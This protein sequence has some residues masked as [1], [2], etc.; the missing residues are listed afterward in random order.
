MS[1]R[2]WLAAA[3]T[4]GIAF[5]AVGSGPAAAQNWPSRPVT[6]VVPF[7]AGSGI[8]VLGRV[9]AA[10]LAEILG[11]QVVVENVGGAGGMTGASRVAKAMPDGYQFLLGNVGTHAQN[12]SLYLKPLY[13]AAMDF[14]PVVLIADT[15]QVLIVRADL[16]VS[17]LQ[18]FVTYAK[19]NQAKMQYGSPGS[20][21]AA[22][23]GCV[24]LNAALGVT[25]THVP[26][27]GGATVMQ[28][29][30]AGRIDYSCPLAA[31]AIPQIQ[32][33]KVKALA[34]LTR[35]RSAILPNLASV[36]EQGLID[37]EVSTWNAFF[38]PKGTPPAIVHR[39]RDSTVAAIDLPAVQERLSRL[40]PNRWRPS[41]ARRAIC[42]NSSKAKSRNGRLR[43]RPR[44]RP[45]I[46]ADNSYCTSVPIPK[47][48][49]MCS[50]L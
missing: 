43:S 35:S 4:V 39:L 36:H 45:R 38:L 14:A 6:M 10:P 18:E 12:Q 23:L 25:V 7:G 3:T 15:P 5:A 22:H 24:L 29:L 2:D 32:S 20:G 26:Y 16:P 11:Q 13:N 30:I 28:D 8:D 33:E 27:R 50:T 46:R 42:K 49:R 37:F 17:N 48:A 47:F 21:S 9:L 41:V 44:E 31:L 1:R 40:E 19:A 34:I